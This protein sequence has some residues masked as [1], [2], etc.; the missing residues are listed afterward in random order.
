VRREKIKIKIKRNT[1]EKEREM[2]TNKGSIEDIN[3]ES[4]S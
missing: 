2:I 3:R 1:N 4:T